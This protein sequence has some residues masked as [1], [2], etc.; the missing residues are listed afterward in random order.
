[1]RETESPTN[2]VRYAGPLSDKQYKMVV[3]MVASGEYPIDAMIARRV[4]CRTQIITDLLAK[5]KELSDLRKSAEREIAQK[6]EQSAVALATGGKNE[7][8]R[9]KAQEFLLKKLMPEK[10]GDN[11]EQSNSTHSSKKIII[12]M[13]LPEVKVDDDGIPIESKSP[14]EQEAIDVQ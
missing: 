12:N 6:V 8:A 2:V 9:Q 1:M 5:D 13:T 7:I 4:G 3:E 11:A 10:Y 14:L